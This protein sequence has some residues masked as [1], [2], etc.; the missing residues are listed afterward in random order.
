MQKSIRPK[1][2]KLSSTTRVWNTATLRYR[3]KALVIHERT[4]NRQKDTSE[5]IGNSCPNSHTSKNGGGENDDVERKWKCVKSICFS[6]L[7]WKVLILKKIWSL[8]GRRIKE[9]FLHVADIIYYKYYYNRLFH[10]VAVLGDLSRRNSCTEFT[11]PLDL[12]AHDGQNSKVVP[13]LPSNPRRCRETPSCQDWR[14]SHGRDAYT[15]QF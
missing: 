14:S 2:K 11:L 5:S 9:E 4:D 1:T 13:S 15:R 12:P 6:S 3:Q 7:N 10:R 8:H